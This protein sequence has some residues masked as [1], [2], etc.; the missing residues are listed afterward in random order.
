M[1]SIVTTPGF[2]IDSRAH[3]EADKVY[4][5]FTRD[6]GL[7]RA[8]AQGIRLEKSKLRYHMENYSFGTFSL[9]R[10]KEI[11]RLTSAQELASAQ[12]LTSVQEFQDMQNLDKSVVNFTTKR[13]LLA[14]LALLLR[15]VLH[16]EEPNYE[17]FG[18][19]LA[20]KEFF[21]N[22][23]FAGTKI[24]H[25]EADF[26]SL[27]SIT[28][29][30]I[31]HSLGYVGNDAEIQEFLTTSVTTTGD[32]ETESKK[33]IITPDLLTKASPKRAIINKHINKAIQE[34]HL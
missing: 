2:I 28:V 9:V 15:R 23:Q 21:A 14:R 34:S 20:C 29:L 8:V 4:F 32:A 22:A 31:L 27:E 5:I 12:K 17:L 25:L 11:W 3:A 6:L 33:L 7:V 13:D 30:R 18:H 16:G 19:L 24:T 10:G 26:Q 1:H